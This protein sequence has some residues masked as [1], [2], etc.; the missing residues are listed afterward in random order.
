MDRS[1]N[2][3]CGPGLMVVLFILTS[4]S[5]LNAASV[6]TEDKT[7][8]LLNWSEN[9]PLSGTVKLSTIA[10]S[11]GESSKAFV[12]STIGTLFFRD[13]HDP[14]WTQAQGTGIS[15][16]FIQKLVREDKNFLQTVLG[17]KEK[18]VDQISTIMAED[19]EEEVIELSEISY[20]DLSFEDIDVNS[21][22]ISDIEFSDPDIELTDLDDI[23]EDDIDTIHITDESYLRNPQEVYE[24]LTSKLK[25]EK[26]QQR[27]I[28]L[29]NLER[30]LSES[31]V[32]FLT[33]KQIVLAENR[34][35][36][37]YVLTP[38]SI[39]VSRDQGRSWQ[40]IL[41]SQWKQ[42]ETFVWM[43][44]GQAP[45]SEII[46]LSNKYVRYSEDRGDHWQQW[47]LPG[48]TARFQ[49]IMF[50]H[51]EKRKA[52]LLAEAALYSFDIGAQLA[53]QASVQSITPE[54]LLVGKH[55]CF[56][57]ADQRIIVAGPQGLLLSVDQGHQWTHLPAEGL[58]LP[59]ISQVFLFSRQPAWILV[60]AAGT[61]YFSVDNGMTFIS[62]AVPRALVE[63]QAL[64]CAP[65]DNSGYILAGI[66]SRKVYFLTISVQGVPETIADVSSISTGPDDDVIQS[67]R[68]VDYAELLA[69]AKKHCL[70]SLSDYERFREQARIAGYFPQFSIY[71]TYFAGDQ[72]TFRASQNI[73]FRPE[74]DR[75]V[76][77]PDSLAMYD[78]DNEYY[79]ISCYLNWN[80]R[81]LLAPDTPN[82]ARQMSQNAKR[83]KRQEQ[84]IRALFSLHEILVQQLQSDKVIDLD[85]EIERVLK[86]N[87]I[88]ALLAAYAGMSTSS[89]E[90]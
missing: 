22:D 67:G 35:A 53:A 70:W 39:F 26:Q 38:Y 78:Y 27:E 56:D 32:T 24:R 81:R 57:A 46:I 43:S 66:S 15:E 36:P 86:T 74:P 45:R 58:P 82:I 65:L 80:L 73:N 40:S 6:E 28:S 5:L 77:G 14:A 2:T 50:Q 44:I 30:A 20:D 13:L 89:T 34:D 19:L 47:S 59:D 23:Q 72:Y 55:T 37:M 31:D 21:V 8:L 84:K 25:A 71:F 60:L 63:F 12:G 69:R 17:I 87:E 16:K 10:L 90:R 18:D 62:L 48:E 49:R 29:H 76:I 61:A 4:S 68:F 3:M 54:A 85:S 83:M 52:L 11:S 88:E 33:I 75:Y 42:G 1:W 41:E 64:A 7:V 51:R 9:S 79:S